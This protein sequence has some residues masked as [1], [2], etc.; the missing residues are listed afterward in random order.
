MRSFV[1]SRWCF[2]AKGVP[3]RDMSVCHYSC[4]NSVTGEM[5]EDSLA[6]APRNERLLFENRDKFDLVVMYDADSE[7]YGGPFM[8]LER[9]I[10]ENAFRKMLKKMPVLLVGGLQAWK[11]EFGKEGVVRGDKAEGSSLVLAHSSNGVNGAGIVNGVAAVPDYQHPPAHSRAPAQSDP[12]SVIMG[13]S[14]SN[15]ESQTVIKSPVPKHQYRQSVDQQALAGPSVLHRRP[16]LSRPPSVQLQRP[17]IPENVSVLL[18]IP[19]TLVTHEAADPADTLCC[20]LKHTISYLP[21]TISVRIST[22]LPPALSV[23]LRL[24]LA[25]QRIPRPLRARL[26]AAPGV[27]QSLTAVSAAQRLHRPVTRGAFGVGGEPRPDRLPRPQRAP[28][29]APATSGRG[30]QPREAAG[31]APAEGDAAADASGDAGRSAGAN[32]TVGLSG[33]VLGRGTA[34]PVGAEE[35]GEYVL[36]ELDDTVFKRDNTV[37]AILSR[38]ANILIVCDAE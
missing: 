28:R 35:H 14:R 10:Y 17:M 26:T 3:H 19:C 21:T 27:H 15:T 36:H 7:S 6:L 34:E 38:Y 25:L 4:S 18:L 2:A 13:R 5:I 8:A 12:H 1:W 33:D 24:V 20:P 30:K 11:Q 9:A 37:R 31:R 29:A 32:D 23:R 22:L 16:A